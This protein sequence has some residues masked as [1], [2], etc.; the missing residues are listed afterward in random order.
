MAKVPSKK[1]D[2]TFFHLF[3][4]FIKLLVVW[5]K[6]TRFAK[7]DQDVIVKDSNSMLRKNKGRSCHFEFRSSA[8]G[9]NLLLVGVSF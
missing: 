4:S 8:L 7:I 1:E 9:I 6:S 2:G 5:K 3:L